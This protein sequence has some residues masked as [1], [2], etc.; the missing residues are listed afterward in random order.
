MEAVVWK[1]RMEMRGKGGSE[2]EGWKRKGRMEVEGKGGR[3]RE[4]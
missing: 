4:A 2:R 3:G 1:G